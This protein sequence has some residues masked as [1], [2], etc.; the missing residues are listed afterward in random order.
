M[1]SVVIPMAGSGQRTGLSV[2]KAFY[3][4]NNKPLFMYAYEVFLKFDCEIILVCKPEEEKYA[5]EFAPEAIT[6]IGGMT[7]AESVRNGLMS[8]HFNKVLIHDAARPFLTG[9]MVQGILNALDDNRCA[10]VG[11]NSHDTIRNT[12]QQVLNREDIIIV[13]TPQA[14]YRDDFLKAFEIGKDVSLTDDIAYLQRFLGLEPAVVPGSTLNFKVTTAD[15]IL[16]A[17]AIKRGEG[18]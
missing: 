8:C 16:L 5:K 12:N 14:G 15:D 6:V 18:I 17:N 2:N 10:Y 11:I 4:I 9:E 3:K 13:Q 1:F 7:R